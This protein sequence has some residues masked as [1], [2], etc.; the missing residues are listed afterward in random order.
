MVQLFSS[1]MGQ[2]LY[3]SP[4]ISP[5][6]RLC[7]RLGIGLIQGILAYSFYR[8][9]GTEAPQTALLVTLA[10]VTAYAPALWLAATGQ[11][12]LR[13]TVVWGTIV[14][15]IIIAMG[16]SSALIPD[17]ESTLLIMAVCLPAALFC[18]HH[19][20]VPAIK[21]K[22]LIAPYESYYETAWKAGIQLVLAL[23][24]LGV[25]WLILLL[26]ALLFNAIGIAFVEDLITK[27]L[28]VCMATPLFFALGVELSD[29]RD[30]LTQGIRIVALTLLSWLLPIAVF[31]AGAFLI[32]LP[33][34][35]LAQLHSSLS[36]AGLMLAASAGLI[37]LLNTVYQD[38]AEHLS[39]I[40]FLRFCLRI[41]VCLLVPMTAFALWAVSVRVGQYGLTLSRIVALSAAIIGFLYALGYTLSLFIRTRNSDGWLPLFE[42]TNIFVGALTV[43]MLLGYSTPWLN[44]I[45]MSLN[46]QIARIESGN[47]DADSIPYL[48]LSNSAG[49]RGE[50]LLEKLSKSS[51]P[52][53]ARRAA[54]TIKGTYQH[55][56][57][58]NRK[59]VV[60]LLPAGTPLPQGLEDALKESNEV[61]LC[62]TDK[63]CPAR[64]Y[65]INGDGRQEVLISNNHNVIVFGLTE[66]GT[67]NQIGK[68]VSQSDC[69]TDM[70]NSQ[71]FRDNP[72]SAGEFE[73]VKPIIIGSARMDYRADK[74]CPVRSD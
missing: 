31:I 55:L 58:N 44:P 15:L 6:Q 42:R 13:A 56:E 65:D 34:A 67:W 53:I 37:V 46:N 11:L 39:P 32:A 19:L 27:P 70:V 45:Q 36:P 9:V 71:N 73:A 49:E 18:M 74:E 57:D 16:L 12:N 25:F 38:G 52:L 51:D 40:P 22:M 5:R 1:N 47:V 30:G 41:G 8:L 20:V 62:S 10:L 63:G 61:Y 66:N 26:G 7:M 72:I 29:V 64:L 33:L 68:F 43:L 48:W 24:F 3:Q 28:F 59:L 23:M 69:A 54:D 4:E 21:A 2:R 35:G 14:T 60:Q 17:Q 50:A